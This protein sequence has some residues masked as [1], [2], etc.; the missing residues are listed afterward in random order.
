M[1][2][3]AAFIATLFNQLII[4]FAK[5]VAVRTAFRLSAIAIVAGAWVTMFAGIKGA[6]ALISLAMPPVFASV[7]HLVIPTGFVASLTLY[8]SGILAINGYRVL[9]E[10]IM[11]TGF[12]EKS[13][14]WLV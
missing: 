5:R 3:L 6:L 1:P 8:W 10:R 2:I 13:D 14:G 12:S 7:L 9:K 4:F 11:N